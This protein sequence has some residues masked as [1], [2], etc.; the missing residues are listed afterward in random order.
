MCKI[1][2]KGKSYCKISVY[3]SFIVHP[4]ILML[5]STLFQYYF[6]KAKREA[7]ISSAMSQ[8]KLHWNMKEFLMSETS[9]EH[10]ILYLKLIFFVIL[11]NGHCIQVHNWKM[12]NISFKYDLCCLQYNICS[13]VLDLLLLFFLWSAYAG[14]LKD[15]MH[16]NQRL[17]CGTLH[18]IITAESHS[19]IITPIIW[20]KLTFQKSVSASLCSW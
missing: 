1:I 15:T 20:E 3:R 18:E 16:Q 13:Y 10:N 7:L 9:L 11:V 14:V 17:N 12:G 8:L 4:Y 19:P 6:Y 5:L 2:L